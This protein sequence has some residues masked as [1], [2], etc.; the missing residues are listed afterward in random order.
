VQ[1]F[2]L[3]NINIPITIKLSKTSSNSDIQLIIDC[4]ICDTIKFGVFDSRSFLRK[5]SFVV[6]PIQWDSKMVSSVKITVT[7]MDNNLSSS[8]TTKISKTFIRSDEILQQKFK[9]LYDSPWIFNLQLFPESSAGP[10]YMIS[11]EIATRHQIN[12]VENNEVRVKKFQVLFDDDVA[13]ITS[14]K[15]LKEITTQPFI[16]MLKMGSVYL[17]RTKYKSIYKVIKKT[18]TINSKTDLNGFLGR[19]SGE[20][21]NTSICTIDKIN[22]ASKVWNMPTLSSI[23]KNVN[24][25]NDTDYAITDFL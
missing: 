4:G 10:A 13:H 11:K 18:I 19:I 12:I 5:K 14:M 9:I 25:S 16:V 24:I 17:C 23:I 15:I 6:R 2:D 3:L 22:V 21:L 20:W 1:W 7:Q 8:K